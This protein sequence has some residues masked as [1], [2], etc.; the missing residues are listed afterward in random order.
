MRFGVAAL[1]S[2]SLWVPNP[3]IT[4]VAVG[5][6][7]L[8]L[9]APAPAGPPP[10]PTSWNWRSAAYLYRTQMERCEGL[11]GERKISAM[12]L[13]LASYSIGELRVLKSPHGGEN[14][15]LQVPAI[16]GAQQTPDVTVQAR[17]GDYPPL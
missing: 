14:F 3:T 5:V 9:A 17:G 15:S 6:V 13:R 2:L 4:V 8:A 1:K 7:V 10:C 16:G 11:R 12:G